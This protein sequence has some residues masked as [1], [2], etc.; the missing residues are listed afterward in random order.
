MVDLGI[1]TGNLAERF[2]H[3]GCKILGVDFSANI[4]ANARTQVSQATL[5]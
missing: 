4:L 3:K 5:V 1:S 2:I